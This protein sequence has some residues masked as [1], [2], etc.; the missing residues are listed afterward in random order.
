MIAEQVEQT[1]EE[2]AL[3]RSQ[4]YKNPHKMLREEST[5]EETP[6][7]LIIEPE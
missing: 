1:I 6:E 7:T 3:L 2:L 5:P 4:G